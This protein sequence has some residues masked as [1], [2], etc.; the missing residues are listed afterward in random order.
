MNFTT[1]KMSLLIFALLLALII[2]VQ[3]AQAVT[4]RFLFWEF[5]LSQILLTIFCLLLG[6]IVGSLAGWRQR[7]KR[8]TIS[9]SGQHGKANQK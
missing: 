4:L 3:N 8:S 7:G 1:L 5:S 2:I 9:G 6:F